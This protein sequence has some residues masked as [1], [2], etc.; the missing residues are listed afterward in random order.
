MM[1]VF[2]FSLAEASAKV[3]MQNFVRSSAPVIHYVE[4]LFTSEN[5]GIDW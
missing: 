2:V 3:Q 4:S 5:L 1:I